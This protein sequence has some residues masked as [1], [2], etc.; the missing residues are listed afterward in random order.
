MYLLLEALR[1]PGAQGHVPGE[2]RVSGGQ[3]NRLPRLSLWHSD[4]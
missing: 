4:T 1:V 2:V 3:P